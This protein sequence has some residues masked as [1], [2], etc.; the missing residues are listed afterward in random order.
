MIRNQRRRV[1]GIALLLGVGLLVGAARVV[2]LSTFDNARLAAASEGQSLRREHLP[3]RRGSLRDRH[4]RLLASS[5][6]TLE[7]AAW[8]PNLKPA[9]KTS[10]QNAER[11]RAIAQTL[12]PWVGVPA[13]ELRAGMVGE[14]NVV[15][16]SPV[17]APDGI[18]L[19]RAKRLTELRQLDFSTGMARRYPW[20]VAAGNLL[21]FVNA[22][23]QGVA[24][25]E[26]GLSMLLSGEDGA[27]RYR[28]DQRGREIAEDGLPVLP[29]MHG[30]DVVL[31]LD[32]ALQQMLEQ[33]LVRVCAEQEAR[34]AFAVLLDTRSAE[35]LA[36]ASVP[37]LNPDDSSDRPRDSVIIGPVQEIYPPGSTFK[38]LMMAA[39]LELGIISADESVDCRAERGV[40]PG[41]RI[42]DT[43]PQDRWLS[44][45]EVIVH[46]SNIGM[47]NI[48]MSLV[49]PDTPRDREAMAPV[50]ELLVRLGFGARI[51]VPLPAEA[52]GMITPLERWH[53]TWTLASVT[54]G[55]EISV[56]AL[57]MAAAVNSLSD[58][59]WRRPS[60]VKGHWSALGEYVE[61]PPA[62]ERVVFASRH[63]ELVRGW[64]A[65]AVAEGS[66]REVKLPGVAVAGK[67][68]TADSEVDLTRE[69][70]SYAALAPAEDPEVTLVVVV[71]EPA[72]AR[73]SS[74]SAAPAAGRILARVLP[75][76]GHPVQ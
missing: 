4:G 71:S 36:L 42:R 1:L 34:R 5:V 52:P 7:L 54:Y 40:L 64:M 23:Q 13:D 28:V 20:G 44:L 15:L 61:T 2:T 56:T 21:G 46:S 75:Y 69:I 41:R 58:G 70:H 11:I 19:L 16:G 24:G 10:G 35:V 50:R 73:Y 37:G 51:G 60:L 29:P 33:E 62:D 72:H 17:S 53:R 8:P 32:V 48:F 26:Q 47:A 30:L 39:A 74:Q 9:H 27:R 3:A 22:E 25:L 76:L 38:P 31:T 55:Q 63:V 65:R 14:R 43:H 59:I 57:Q 67:T 6:E 66:C 18:E 49:S 12:A 68:G 45:E